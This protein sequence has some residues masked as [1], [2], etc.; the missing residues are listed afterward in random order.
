M[1][2]ALKKEKRKVIVKRKTLLE[3]KPKTSMG[4]NQIQ[5]ASR[6]IKNNMDATIQSTRED[7]QQVIENFFAPVEF[8]HDGETQNNELMRYGSNTS[9]L[10]SE[11]GKYNSVKRYS[12]I[13]DTEL[14]N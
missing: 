1:E 6:N 5:V 2:K 13:G 7:F 9:L 11:N 12:L 8:D 10:K 14:L 4:Q 3:A